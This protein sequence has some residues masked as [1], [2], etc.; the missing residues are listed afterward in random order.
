MAFAIAGFNTITVGG[1]GRHVYR[2]ED[3]KATILAAN[4]FDNAA[5]SYRVKVGEVVD[6]V[7]DTEG[8]IGCTSA[9]INAVTASDSAPNVEVTQ[10]DL[11]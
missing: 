8:T 11:A 4:Y 7:Y 1:E 2:S 10:C 3:A 5:L 9:V 6:I